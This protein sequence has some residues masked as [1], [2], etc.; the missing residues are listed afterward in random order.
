VSLFEAGKSRIPAPLLSLLVPFF[1]V[2]GVCAEESVYWYS[3][4][5]EASAQ[6]IPAN[7]PMMIDFWAT[8]CLPC[9]AMD[10]Q[11][12]S[13]AEFRQ[14]AKRFLPVR[15]DYDK[16]TALARKYNVGALPTIVFADSY[17]DELFRYEGYVGAAPLLALV[18]ALPGNVTEFN[19]LNRI[20][21]QDKNNFEALDA[22]GRRLREAGL[23]RASSDYYARAAREPAAR[24]SPERREAIFNGIASNFLEVKDGKLAAEWFENCLKTFPNSPRK[25]EWTLNLARAYAFGEKK[26]KQKA[27]KILQTLIQA[28]PTAPQCENA[29][30]LLSSL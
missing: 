6:A 25:D 23:F 3:T 18:N 19:R 8:W 2:T 10:Q 7:R 21:A 26:D 15:I 20:L 11:V 17:G 16:K 24:S 30:R 29:R 22:M 12:Y 13:T 27:R 4:V 9:K 5:E 28:D 1:A 14:A